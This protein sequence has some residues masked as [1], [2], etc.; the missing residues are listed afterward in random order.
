MSDPPALDSGTALTAVKR[1]VEGMRAYERALATRR[2]AHGA[3]PRM[4]TCIPRETKQLA[5]VDDALTAEEAAARHPR[6]GARRVAATANEVIDIAHE[7]Q[8][9]RGVRPRQLTT[10][11]SYP[12]EKSPILLVFRECKQGLRADDSGTT[13]FTRS[14]GNVYVIN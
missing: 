8:G 12:H 13:I 5:D 1:R 10:S 14:R 11:A 3:A 2:R 4:E 9:G 7:R 6:K